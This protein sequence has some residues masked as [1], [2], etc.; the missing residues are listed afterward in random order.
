MPENPES[1][2]RP[3]DLWA[4]LD[5]AQQLS[6]F[7]TLDHTLRQILDLAGR[8]TGAEAGSVILHDQA[9]NDLYFAASTGPVADRLMSVRLPVGQDRSKAG[10]VFETRRAIVE[11]HVAG[12]FQAVDDKTE[13]A[14]KSMICV[15]LTRGEQTFGVMQLLNKAGGVEPF[16]EPDLELVTRFAGLAAAGIGNA[17]VFEQMLSSSG[18]FAKPEVR[19]DLIG[20]LLTPGSTPIRERLTVLFADMRAF[21]R[22]ATAVVRPEKLQRILGD[23]LGMMSEVVLR[24]R[25]IVNKFLGDGMLAVFRGP[26]AATDAIEAAFDMGNGFDRLKEAW[27]DTTS[28]TLDFLDI[29][30]GIA[31]DDEIVLGRI[32]D[33]RFCEMTVVG[34]GVNLAAALQEQARDGK[35]VICDHQTLRKLTDRSAVLA[36]A[37]TKFT[38]MTTG[39]PAGMEFDVYHIHRAPPPA[40]RPGERYDVFVSYRREGGSGIARAIQQGLSRDFRVFLDVD[41]LR[42]GTFDTA[43]LH[44]IEATPN[45]LLVLSAGAFDRCQNPDDWLRQELRQALRAGRNIVPVALEGF[46]FP[47]AEVLPEDIRPVARRDAIEYSHR[48]FDAM[49]TKVRERLA[50]DEDGAPG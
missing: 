17:L 41:K 25:G 49:L 11:N 28:F 16:G 5:A 34:V 47:P 31:T 1:L 18:L 40:L 23:H 33:D 29:G 42:G 50:S 10:A 8:L 19:A 45:F 12:H 38:L 13:F 2:L 22:L 3:Q 24:H 9:R 44:T 37:P 30:V 4:L 48:Y 6:S 7:E 35:R 43:L 21:T 20:Q 15:P 26:S 39:A 27:A 32:G 14:T 46:T 36:D